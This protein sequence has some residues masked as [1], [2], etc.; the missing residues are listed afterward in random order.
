MRKLKNMMLAGLLLWAGSAGAQSLPSLH[1]EGRNLVDTH[2]NTV[3]L[4]GV[5]DTPSPY[6]NNNRWGN[7]ATDATK[8][9]CIEY[10][11]KLFTALTDTT[12]GAYCTVFRLHLDPCWTNDPN[13]PSTGPE[14]GE[15]NIS[16]FSER[17]LQI[18]LNTLYC[19]IIDR[20]LSHGL[21]VIV[22]P[23][24]V[25]PGGIK[26]GGYYQDYLMTVWDLVSK[27]ER[28]KEWS[29]QVSL[30]LA[31]EPVNVYDEDS[32]SNPRALHDF[33]QP[34][35]DK[36]RSN[37]FD[38]IIWVPGRGWQSN[39]EDYKDN[40]I[41][42]YNIGYAVHAYVG[43]YNQVRAGHRN[44]SHHGDG[45]GLEPRSARRRPLQ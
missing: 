33:F 6:F 37:G 10:F 35:V 34:I 15:A 44:Q 32:L 30:E 16:Q 28:I 5:M 4:H 36:I 14:T 29:G 45:G 1:V 2:G 25:C 42:G 31:N 27:N 38:G 12:Q 19:E 9:D 8:K 21:Y 17:R 18:Y 23:P 22:R 3:V 13:I 7:S 20:A 39:Y 26:V 41:T 24:G 40:P 43:W 11:D